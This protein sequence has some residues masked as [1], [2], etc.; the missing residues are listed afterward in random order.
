LQRIRNAVMRY[1]HDAG[2]I[3]SL[4]RG[5]T[6]RTNTQTHKHYFFRS[7]SRYAPAREKRMK[8]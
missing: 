7:H 2:Y 6:T 3:R 8:R 5:H 4:F 1:G